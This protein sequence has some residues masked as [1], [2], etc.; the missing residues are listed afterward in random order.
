MLKNERNFLKVSSKKILIETLKELLQDLLNAFLMKCLIFFYIFEAN[1]LNKYL[2]EFLSHCEKNLG[3]TPRW[4][5][6]EIPE[7]IIGEILDNVA[8][9][10]TVVEV[11][12]LSTTLLRATGSIP[13]RARNFP[14]F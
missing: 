9:I 3:W 14:F 12:V 5:I 10:A 13:G 1:S 6:W 11:C 8:Y 7:W 2:E 4:I